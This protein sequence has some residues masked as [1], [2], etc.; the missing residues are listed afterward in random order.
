MSR[1]GMEIAIEYGKKLK[2][3]RDISKAEDYFFS[4]KDNLLKKLETFCAKNSCFVP[5][6]TVESLKKIEK[7]YF[8]FV[9]KK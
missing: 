7:W 5:D 4:Y 6:Y 9:V 1:Y 2:K 8:D 3:F